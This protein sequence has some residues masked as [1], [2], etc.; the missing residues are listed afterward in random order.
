MLSP[1]TLILLGNSAGYNGIIFYMSVAAAAVVC[2]ICACSIFYPG[3]VAG[4][5][6]E[7]SLLT[8]GIGRFPGAS[9]VLSARLAMT[10]LAATSV[11]VIAGY[12]FNEIF[13]YWFPN[14]GFAF[15]L[16]GLILI[17]NLLRVSWATTLQ[18]LLVVFT[19]LSFSI[20][21][22]SGLLSAPATDITPQGGEHVSLAA[23]AGAL[24]LF[25]GF[26][27]IINSEQKNKLI[28]AIVAISTI[29]ILFVLWGA[30]S[31]TYVPTTS[32]TE[33]TLPHLTAA[34]AVMGQ[35]GRLLMGIVVI[36]GATATVNGLF[37]Y[38]GQ[39]VRNLAVHE[40]LPS[41]GGDTLQRLAGIL[42]AVT[43]GI[44]M[45]T[46]LAG[47]PKL[48]I[49]YRGA[50]LL[51]LLLLAVRCL[52]MAC[53]PTVSKHF[54]IL[55]L[56]AG[57]TMGITS[58]IIWFTAEYRRDLIVFSLLVYAGGLLLVMVWPAMVKLFPKLKKIN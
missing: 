46:G 47:D 58:I 43:I 2:F 28:P 35:N 55:G 17:C 32:L 48:T 38:M 7:L 39:T 51:W 12:A 9:L 24:L 16:L 18:M 3:S 23:A 8:R 36:C 45:M 25:L 50:L 31:R 10:L 14:F 42:M 34:R 13:L 30:V 44:L 15:L 40:L 6:N 20:L 37:I 53:Q 27:L 22:I 26:D 52:A 49:Y 1:E 5:E 19:L 57:C 41:F 33:S 11:L 56:A 29:F 4:E 54:S 21:L